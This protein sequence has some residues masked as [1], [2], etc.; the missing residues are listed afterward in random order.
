MIN[1]LQEPEVVRYLNSKI[2]RFDILNHLIE[3]YRLVNYLEI[4][5]FQGENIRLV[6]AA[7]KDGV[8]PGHEGY[9]VPEVNYPITS[10]AFF[11]LIEGHN[12]IKYD[13]IF[14]DGLHE[15]FQVKK[16]I[17]NS[18]KHLQPNGFIVMHDCNP[19]S[20]DAQIPDRKTI[21]WNGDV[22]K[23]FVEFKQNNPNFECCVVD[24]DFGVGFIKNNGESFNS[25]PLLNMDYQTFDS[26]RKK[27]LNL[28][29]WDEFK[30]TY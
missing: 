24:T 16:D 14:I 21:A 3:K 18:L 6:K 20:Y 4:G 27:Y 9:V 5:V 30:T 13:L 22:W 25:T 29:T 17:E 23:A 1:N 7:H 15:Y 8:D 26:D 2:K 10:D 11:E 19:V 28:I 12:E